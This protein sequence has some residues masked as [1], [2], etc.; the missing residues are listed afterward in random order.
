MDE[1]HVSQA[2]H[3]LGRAKSKAGSYSNRYLTDG[4]VDAL[5]GLGHALLAIRDELEKARKGVAE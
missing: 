2:K 3:F 4:S 5:I 1:G